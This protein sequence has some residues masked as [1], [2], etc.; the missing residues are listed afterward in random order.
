M[1]V[2]NNII[3]IMLNSTIKSVCLNA[4]YLK[5]LPVASS[6]CMFVNCAARSAHETRINVQL[7][8]HMH[9]HDRDRLY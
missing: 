6:H 1:H 9:T 3:P 5:I 4:E 7:P 8:K 2:Y